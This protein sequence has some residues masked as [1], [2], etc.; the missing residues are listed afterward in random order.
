[1]LYPNKPS[2]YLSAFSSLGQRRF[3]ELIARPVTIMTADAAP[4]IQTI[5]S[6]SE[7]EF[8]IGGVGD[9]GPCEGGW[10]CSGGGVGDGCGIGV[11][12]GVGNCWGT[13]EG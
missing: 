1:V 4:A 5:E 9:E 11:G 13:G 2:F 3:L 6:G 10:V 7:M 12:C 8:V